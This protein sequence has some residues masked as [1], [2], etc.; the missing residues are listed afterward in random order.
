[1]TYVAC[2]KL[3]LGLFLL[4]VDWQGELGRDF[5]AL[6]LIPPPEEPK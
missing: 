1:M 4:R 3:C 5:D 2:S 6:A